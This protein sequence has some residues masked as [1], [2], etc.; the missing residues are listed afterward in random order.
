MF[1]FYQ[2]LFPHSDHEVPSFYSLFLF[3]YLA[4]PGFSCG[5]WIL[6]IHRG[7]WDF[8]C[9]V[10]DLVSQVAS[11]KDSIH[12][13]SRRCKFH[14]W[15][16][17]IP[18]R[19]KWQATPV[20]LLGKSMDRGAWQ[21]AICGITRVR[22]QWHVGSSFLTADLIVHWEWAVLATGPQGSPVRPLV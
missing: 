16:G 2:M 4:A 15:V 8:S 6:D 7:V 20:L 19:R 9:S 13:P 21:A 10:W 1:W 12:L 22:K 5:T 14:P 17:K 11:G 18:W 3:I